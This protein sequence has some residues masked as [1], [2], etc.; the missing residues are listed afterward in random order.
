[1]SLLEKLLE[2]KDLSAYL[3]L[4]LARLKEDSRAMNKYP[5]KDR[6]LIRERIEGR[7]RELDR[8]KGLLD[9]NYIKA[10]CKKMWRHFDGE[11]RREQ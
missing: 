7:I 10:D 8:L 3:R 1:V 5:E 11:K 6:E 9:A 4:R 2:K